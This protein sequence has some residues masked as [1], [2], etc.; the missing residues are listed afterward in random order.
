MR[1]TGTADALSNKN[2]NDFECS[3]ATTGSAHIEL[4]FIPKQKA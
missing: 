3:H 2:S 1:I 4:L